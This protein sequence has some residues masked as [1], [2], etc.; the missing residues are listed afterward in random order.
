MLDR[1]IRTF[2]HD[3]RFRQWWFVFFA[4]LVDHTETN[5]AKISYLA[6]YRFL[7]QKFK[8]PFRSLILKAAV[9]QSLHFVKNRLHRRIGTLD[10]QTKLL[11]FIDN[12]AASGEIGDQHALM[13][14]NQLGVN[15]FVGFTVLLHRSDME[16]TFVSEGTHAY[17]GL[18]L[19]RI[20][21]G[22]FIH[23]P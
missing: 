21:I 13:I 3:R 8:G 6:M 17:V 14:A 12:V 9:L 20:E 4:F 15:V 10:I 22:Q 18:T 19:A 16:S 7:H 11:G 23:K 2:D 5:Q 1:A